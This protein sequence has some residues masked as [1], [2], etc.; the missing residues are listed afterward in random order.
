MP[1]F[2]FSQALTANQTGFNPIENWQ[3][4]R[5]PIHWR[6]A[7][8]RLF[9]RATTVGV[10]VSV[11]A[12]SDNVVQRSNVQGGGTAGVTPSQL[13]TTPF[14]FLADPGDPILPLFDEVAAGTPTL[15]GL[16]EIE[17]A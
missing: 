15:D 9:A 5:V 8:V 3:Y 2:P 7:V 10:R 1:S 17:P 16:V 14:V 4:S 13:N 6:Q 12:G 11:F